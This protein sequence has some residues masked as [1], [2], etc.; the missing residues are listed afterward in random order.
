MDE[1][2]VA[3]GLGGAGSVGRELHD[4]HLD[5]HRQGKRERVCAGD[6]FVAAR[7]FVGVGE[8]GRLGLDAGQHADRGDDVAAHQELGGQRYE[9]GERTGHEDAGDRKV[10]SMA[11]HDGVGGH[12]VAGRQTG[13]GKEHEDPELAE[14]QVSGVRSPGDGSGTRHH[15]E[16]E[17]D[18]EWPR[19]STQLDVDAARQW[20]PDRAHEQPGGDTEGESEGIDLGDQSFGVA[21]EPGHPAELLS[22]SDDT[23]PITEFEHG[24][25]T[26]DE[27]V[28]RATPITSPSHRIGM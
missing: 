3:A 5:D 1:R 14:D 13:A 10:E 25:V 16:A 9:P 11:R 4:D 22:R 24:L 20:Q 23:D 7:A 8:G 17:A 15:A 18:D 6:A 21:E 2:P 12:V 27:I 19:A 28:V 26:G